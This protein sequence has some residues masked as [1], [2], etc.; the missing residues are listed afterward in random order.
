MS[1]GKSWTTFEAKRLHEM[2]AARIPMRKIAKEL[3]RTEQAVYSFLRYVPATPDSPARMKGVDRLPPLPKAERE[4][5]ISRWKADEI[6]SLREL[7][8]AGHSSADIG[9]ILNRTAHAIRSKAS[10]LG[11]SLTRRSYSIYR[12]EQEVNH[13]RRNAIEGSALLR[14]AILTAYPQIKSFLCAQTLGAESPCEKIA[15]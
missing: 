7:A 5:A 10:E 11:I 6:E 12:L 3:G 8:E 9:E 2:R 14:D 4:P 13:Y 1:G 15:A